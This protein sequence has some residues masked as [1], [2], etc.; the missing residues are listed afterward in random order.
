MR[1]RFAKEL[2]KYMADENIYL[3]TA[4]LGYKMFDRIKK[5]YPGRFID[6]G[7]AEQAAVGMAIGLSIERKIP[8]VYS[9]TPFLLY[10]PFE[11]IRNYVA[12]GYNVKLVGSGRNKDYSQDGFTHWA[13][14]ARYF[15]FGFPKIKQFWPKSKLPME[16][17]LY[18]GKPSFLSLK[19]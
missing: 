8:V 1:R 3:I 5:K 2:E 17:F 16:E 13:D 12:R 14:D 6:V 15:L 7:V 9:I 4:N 11:L 10:R 19:R 18:N